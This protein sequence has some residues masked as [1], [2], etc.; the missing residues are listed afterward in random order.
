MFMAL[1]AFCGFFFL[2]GIQ[3]VGLVG[4]DEPRYAQV[5][6]EMLAAP[7][8]GHAGA[9]RQAMAGKAPALL[10][11]AMLAYQGAGG[12][13]D[14]A[15]RLPSAIL[16]SL[17][18]FF[19]YLW[20]RRFRR[21]MQ[22]DAALITAA[23]AMVI[24]FGRSASTDMPLTVMFTAA[25]L[26]WYG[27]HA[28]QNRG[29]LLGFLFLLRIGNAGQRTGRG[30]SG[31][32][33]YCGVRWLRRDGRL[34]LRTLWPAGIAA[35][36]GSDPAL[37][38]CGAASESRVLPRLLSPAQPGA[39]HHRPLPPSSALLVLPAGCSAGVGAVDRL[40]DCGDRGCHSRLAVLG[41][42]AAGQGR[43]A[44]LPNAMA[45]AADRLLL[46]FAVEAAGIHSARDPGGYDPAGRL[47]PAP[48]RRRRKSRMSG[49]RCCTRLL[50]AVM[51][52][53]ALIVPFKLLK[54][55]MPRKVIIV[56]VALCVT[57]VLALW[58][59]LHNYGYRILRFTTLVAG[60]HRILAAAA[61][62]RRRSSMSCSRRARYKSAHQ[63][64]A[65]GEI[66]IGRGLRR[67]SL[68]W[69]TGW[70]F[71]RN[72][73]IPSYERNEIPAGDHLVVAAAGSQN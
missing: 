13:S 17:M 55:A 48:R 43:P 6:R 70:R 33:N 20:S 52:V 50:S 58:L 61:W 7:R 29:W 45:A 4:A 18:V 9:L 36:S 57:A 34:M 24:G 2:A 38:H 66:P 30:I 63:P 12:V 44:H 73:P 26:C 60:G 56:A 72:H 19:I 53:A 67:A 16:C 49:C 1:M 64:F 35:V 42:A 14:W 54:L 28:S 5:A 69:N 10:L 37:V 25:M 65:L 46:L 11:V 68:A 3:L 41:A 31:G 22:L 71:Y 27:W 40:C 51:L 8:L 47:H 32:V 21:G 23:S 15:A 59:S 62:Q 39:L